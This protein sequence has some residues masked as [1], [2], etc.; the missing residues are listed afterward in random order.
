MSLMDG[1]VTVRNEETKGRYGGSLLAF[2]SFGSFWGIMGW[3]SHHY[4]SPNDE[5]NLE[6]EEGD[7]K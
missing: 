4:D 5:T 3:K 2:F 6:S 1:S 7:S